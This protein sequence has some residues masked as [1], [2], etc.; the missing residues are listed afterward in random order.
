MILLDRMIASRR[1][2]EFVDEL[3][4]IYNEE[5]QEDSIWEVWL[6]RVFDKTFAEF[7]ASL[8]PNNHKAAPTQEEVKGIVTDSMNTLAC[9]VPQK[10]L[11][12]SGTVQAAGNNSG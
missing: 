7:K 2:E 9:F 10:E 1:L 5:K 4:T 12:N 3:V 11:V 8:D 6:H